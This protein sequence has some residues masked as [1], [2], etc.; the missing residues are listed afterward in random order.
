MDELFAQHVSVGS[1][2]GEQDSTIVAANTTADN[3]GAA[4]EASGSGSLSPSL[5]WSPG[6]SP[7]VSGNSADEYDLEPCPLSSPCSAKQR[8]VR[9][10]PCIPTLKLCAMQSAVGRCWGGPSGFSGTHPINCHGSHSSHT[11]A[12]SW[13]SS[14]AYLLITR[15]MCLSLTDPQDLHHHRWRL[16]LPFPHPAPKAPRAS[17]LTYQ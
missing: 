9:L 13:H 7:E 11:I 12:L 17:H 8:S 4:N 16:C 3:R 5:S 6:D 2:P 14:N 1:F 10:T 15:R